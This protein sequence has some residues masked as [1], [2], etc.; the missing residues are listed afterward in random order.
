MFVIDTAKKRDI[1][2]VR[3]GDPEFML[4]DGFIQYPRAM[5]HILPE[6]PNS[7]RDNINWA[8]QNG[9]L[10]CVANVQGKE[11]TWQTLTK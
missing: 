1:R 10:K 11:L 9:Y 3:Q 6:C 4:D 8:F 5:L 7:I 2:Q